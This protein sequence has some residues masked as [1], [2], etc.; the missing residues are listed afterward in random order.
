MVI[1]LSVFELI[2]KRIEANEQEKKSERASEREP[3]RLLLKHK[4]LK[5]PAKP[6]HRQIRMTC[7]CLK[8][9]Q[10]AADIETN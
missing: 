7:R 1:L 10:Q 8:E 2:E 9:L 6:R 5:S 3:I 4:A